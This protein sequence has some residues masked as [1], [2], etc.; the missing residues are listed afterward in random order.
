[1]ASVQPE[2]TVIYDPDTNEETY[3]KGCLAELQKAYQKEAEPLIKRL[4]AIQATK[5]PK[6][7]LLGPS[8]TA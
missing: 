8:S 3:L 2:I 1:M 7:V 6:W 5:L 4:A